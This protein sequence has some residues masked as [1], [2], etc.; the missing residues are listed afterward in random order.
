M[1]RCK[2]AESKS[3]KNGT[4]DFHASIQQHHNSLIIRVSAVFNLAYFFRQDTPPAIFSEI[5]CVRPVSSTG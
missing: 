4:F 2:G 3:F 5:L 1:H